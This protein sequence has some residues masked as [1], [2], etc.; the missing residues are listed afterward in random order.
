MWGRVRGRRT[1]PQSAVVEVGTGSRP[2]ARCSPPS[3]SPTSTAGL[4]PTPGNDGVAALKDVNAR[5]L[6]VLGTLAAAVLV[7]GLWPA[8]LIE[9]MDVSIDNLL[10]HIAVSKL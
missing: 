5:E 9:V 1:L 6:F 2:A 3:R 8:P 4:S 7:L 10:R